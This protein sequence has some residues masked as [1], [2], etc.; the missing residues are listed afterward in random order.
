MFCTSG[1]YNLITNIAF[2]TSCQKDLDDTNTSD[3][4]DLNY[5][6]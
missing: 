6:T 2:G 4:C 1:D 3:N 5:I